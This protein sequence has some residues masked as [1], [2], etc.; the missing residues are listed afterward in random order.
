MIL[1]MLYIEFGLITYMVAY[2]SHRL[3]KFKFDRKEFII[4][5]F[6]PVLN[7]I[8]FSSELYDIY[9]WLFKKLKINELFT[10]ELF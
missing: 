10:K 1:F 3:I 7:M 8:V 4:I 2:T 5:C 9:I 6:V